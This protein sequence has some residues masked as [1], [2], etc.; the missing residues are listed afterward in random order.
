[1]AESAHF[2]EENSHRPRNLFPKK[3][4]G[5]LPKKL[6]SKLKKLELNSTYLKLKSQKT[7]SDCAKKPDPSVNSGL[8]SKVRQLGSCLTQGQAVTSFLRKKGPVNAF[9]LQSGLSLSRGALKMAPLSQTRWM[10]L[11]SVLWSTQPARTSAF[12]QI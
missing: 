11:K 7:C 9:P 6:A 1:M 5:Q 4:N 8:K 3:R 12:S 2:P 10:T